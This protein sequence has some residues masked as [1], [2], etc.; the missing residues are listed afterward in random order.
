MFL[1]GWSHLS[2]NLTHDKMWMFILFSIIWSIWILR[3][4]MVL[5]EKSLDFNVDGACN[6]EG[7]YGVEGVL[8]DQKGNVLMEFSHSNSFESAFLVE[9]LAIKY[10]LK[11]F[12]NSN[13]GHKARLIVESDSKNLGC[14]D[15]DTGTGT[16]NNNLQNY[17]V[18]GR[19]GYD[20]YKI[21]YNIY[22]NIINY[23]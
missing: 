10:A 17:R 2:P 11:Y 16:E 20:K 8:R 5:Q 13:W 3:N 23:K 22:N 14:I 6:T 21:N 4:K 7:R 18:R 1:L 15:T 9:T 19:Q 12:I